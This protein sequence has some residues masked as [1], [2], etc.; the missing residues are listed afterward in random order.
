MFYDLIN[1]VIKQSFVLLLNF[2]SRRSTSVDVELFDDCYIVSFI[3]KLECTFISPICVI[4][5]EYILEKTAFR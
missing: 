4:Q 1:E 3:Y 2:G 5:H